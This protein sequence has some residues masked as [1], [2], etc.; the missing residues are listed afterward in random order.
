MRRQLLAIGFIFILVG[1]GGVSTVPVSGKVILD[2]KPLAGATVT[3]TPAENKGAPGPS[4]S[5]VTDASGQYSLALTTDSN[6]KGAVVGKHKISISA[7]EGGTDA[8]AGADP[9]PRVEKVPAEYNVNST[10]TFDVPP[11]GTT[12]ADFKIDSPPNAAK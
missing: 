3:F 7:I 8:P 5:G 10:R 6:I 12:S 1:C 9:K 4:S 2:G 11:G